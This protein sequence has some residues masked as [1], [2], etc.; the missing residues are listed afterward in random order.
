MTLYD[1]YALT[2]LSEPF[3]V[4]QK[5]GIALLVYIFYIFSILNLVSFYVIQIIVVS[6][7]ILSLI[8]IFF[9]KKKEIFY[10]EKTIS[11][12]EYVKEFLT[13]GEYVKVAV[14]VSAGNRFYA[15]S[16]YVLNKNRTVNFI[17]KGTLKKY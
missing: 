9:H 12:I 10:K 5:I 7:V 3:I 11:N 4:L 1:C 6:I 14:R 16:M 2:R 15:R 8:Y 17:K 13:N